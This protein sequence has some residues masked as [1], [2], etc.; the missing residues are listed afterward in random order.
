MEGFH[1]FQKY[2]ARHHLKLDFSKLDIEEVEKKI[3]GDHPTEAATKNE[4]MPDVVENIP[5]DSSLSSLP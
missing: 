2:L 4:V 1:L 3:L 5:T